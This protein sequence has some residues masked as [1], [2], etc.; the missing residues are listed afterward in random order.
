MVCARQADVLRK[1]LRHG[2][3]DERRTRRIHGGVCRRNG[4]RASTTNKPRRF[5][6][7]ATP[8]GQDC[9]GLSRNRPN[10]LP[11]SALAASAISPCNMPRRPVSG[12][13]R[14]RTRGTTNRGIRKTKSH[15]RDLL[16][17]RDRQSLR[18]RRRRQSALSCSNH[19][20][21]LKLSTLPEPAATFAQR[22]TCDPHLSF[23]GH[24]QKI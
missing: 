20:G 17:R 15:D 11:L 8:S 2:S 24:K 21:R 16:F 12:Q 18:M 22:V 5:S 14:S 23:I 10:A 1:K 9:A 19:A 7:Q 3:A 13:S 4:R 6:A